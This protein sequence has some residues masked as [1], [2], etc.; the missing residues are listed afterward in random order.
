MPTVDDVLAALEMI[1]P[2]ALAEDW[3]NV[4]LLL[5]DRRRPVTAV[6]TCLTLTPDVAR[7]AVDQRCGLV[8][9]HHPILFRATKQLTADTAEGAMLLQLIEAGVAVCSPHTGYDSSAEGINQ[10][11]AERLGLTEVNPLRPIAPA[12]GNAGVVGG[13]RYGRWNGGASLETLLQRVKAALQIDVLPFV[14]DPGQPVER[15]AVACG[16]AAEFLPDALRCGCQALVTGEARFHA[17]LEART[18]GI[19]LL[20]AG[21]YAT[22]RFAL[23]SLAERLRRRFPNVAIGASRVERDPIQWS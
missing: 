15:I 17:C 8:I 1:A 12:D 19:A 16:S 2:A 4:G 21:H 5:G 9:A 18:A 20:L 6:L 14:G 11:L 23:E 22:E 10:Q 3:D 13:G 7:E